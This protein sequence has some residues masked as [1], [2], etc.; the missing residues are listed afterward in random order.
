MSLFDNLDVWASAVGSTGY[1]NPGTPGRTNFL[2]RIA[3]D[4]SA[5]S[6]EFVLFAGGIN[7][8]SL[9]SNQLAQATLQQ[10]CL[11][12]YQLIQ[13]N[14]PGCKIVA[15]GPFWPR[16]PIDP[17]AYMVNGAISNACQL[18]GISGCYIDTLSDPWVTGQ[19]NIPG[20]GNAVVYTSSDGTHPTSAGAWNLASHVAAAL[21]SRF[22]ELQPHR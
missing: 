4:V 19:W 10:A 15:L 8:A 6:P 18:A 5:F 3:Y 9:T 20:S 11:D 12:C 2:S 22:P 1:L 7:D 21:S 13:S 17:A 16:T 14:V